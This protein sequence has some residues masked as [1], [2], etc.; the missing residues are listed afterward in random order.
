MGTF[1]KNLVNVRFT[2]GGGKGAIVPHDQDA[3]HCPPNGEGG[4]VTTPVNGEF[5]GM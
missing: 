1:D 4:R 5:T 2:P 3:A